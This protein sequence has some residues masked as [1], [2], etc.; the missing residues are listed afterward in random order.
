M[1]KKVISV[2]LTLTIFLSLFSVSF[3]ATDSVPE[4]NRKGYILGDT[5]NSGEINI[6][7]CTDIQRYLASLIN[8]EDVN[9]CA[10]DTNCNG[11]VSISDATVIQK[12]LAGLP[13][14]NPVG[15]RI[16]PDTESAKANIYG[17]SFDTTASDSTC[18]RTASAVNMKADYIIGDEY[19]KLGFN[20]FDYAYP[21][22]DIRRCNL[23]VSNAGKKTITYEGEESFATDGSNGNVMVEIPKFY[24]R[25]SLEGTRETWEITG[26][27]QEGFEIEPAF[28]DSKGNELDYIYIGAY[29]FSGISD[30]KLHSVADKQVKT[31]LTLGMYR[32]IARECN[33]SCIDYATLHALQFL[34]T[35]EFAD[36]DTD[37]YMQGISALPFFNYSNC[38]I[39]EI[40]QDRKTVTLF[41]GKR[42]K[43][44]RKGQN[45]LICRN[46]TTLMKNLTITEVSVSE[47][48][49]TVDI[50]FDRAVS[51]S[52]DISTGNVYVAGQPQ[53]TGRCDNLQYHTGRVCKENNVSPFRYRYME[54]LWGNAWKLVE[55]LR[56]KEL[57]YYYTYNTELYGDN[58][59]SGWKKSGIK[60]PEQPNLGDNVFSK[61][62]ITEMGFDRDDSRMILPSATGKDGDTGKFYSSAFYSQYE[63]DRNGNQLDKETEYLCIYGGGFDHGFLCG[64]FTMRFWF[65]AG[66]ERSVLHTSRLVLR[67]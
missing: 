40:S 8:V 13:D 48:E 36:R 20:D 50:T 39:T 37:K 3:R 19:S 23:T 62:W 9:Y 52:V 18:K 15:E 31:A 41:Y 56:V 16:I 53:S 7:D 25:R 63:I 2:I 64:A 28:I 58:T 51:D 49:K 11:I 6:N 61:A 47:S 35:I 12:Y 67:K 38:P 27:P 43:F 5:D 60:T 1:L 65:S 46:M 55:G 66:K 59:V 24:T 34:F 32:N 30:T 54:N 29:E 57:E 4:I 21:W 22:C 14:R 42:T 26:L 17:I 45:V 44:F 10:I 33:M